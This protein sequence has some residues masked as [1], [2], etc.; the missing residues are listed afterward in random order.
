[1]DNYQEIF[2]LQKDYFNKNNTYSYIFR[3]EMLNRLY[4]MI[5][6]NSD[7]LCEA[8]NKDLGKSK[9]ESYMCE[10][11]LLLMHIKKAIKH[12]KKLMKPKKVH[13]EIFNFLAKSKILYDPYGVT[14]I[15]S[16]WNYPLLLALD[17]LIGAISGG[18]T[19]VIKLSEYSV[20]TSKLLKSLINE[21]FNKEYIYA[22]DGDASECA[23]ILELPFDF[24]FFT[25]STKVGKIVLEKASAHLTPVC[26]ELGGKSPCIITKDANLRLAARRIVFGKILN[27]AQTCVAPDYIYIDET[28]KDEFITYLIDEILDKLGENPCL[29]PDYPKIISQKHLDRLIN[30]IDK[31]KLRYGGKSLNQKLEPTILDN[32]S[33]DDQ[34]MQEE[35]FGPILPVVTYKNIYDVYSKLKNSPTPLAL[36]LFTN[37]NKIIKEV[38]SYIRFGGGCI[39]DTIMHLSSDNL[40]FG[41]VGESGMGNYHGKYSFYT[42]THPKSIL[43]KS[44]KMD[45]K[46]RYYPYTNKKE[47]LIKKILK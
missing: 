46:L 30:L 29:N 43:Y 44:T 40:P 5:K 28:V 6:L 20:H 36:Y 26:L 47:K 42:F 10:V 25:G 3:K 17:P 16:P 31:T 23:T 7:S 2:N 8:L 37:D 9:V 39:N 32:V 12:L 41:G 45:I 27:A 18:N 33:F 35:I 38:T 21:T 11:G 14:L 15:I 4:N 13:T 24:I 22:Y 34:V 1:M 19:A